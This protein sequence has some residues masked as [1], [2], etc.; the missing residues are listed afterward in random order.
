MSKKDSE[1]N[2]KQKTYE[3][4]VVTELPD[5]EVQIEGEIS[6]EV[7]ESYRKDAVKKINEKITLPGFRKG[8]VPEKI[9][10]S[11]VG[12]QTILEEMAEMAL[13]AAYPHLIID[14]KL[15]TIGRPEITITKIAAGNPLGFK[16][17]TAV[18][19][20]ITLPDYKKIA[21]EEMSKKEE[22]IA[23]DEKELE[24]AITEIRK[25]RVSH[26]GHDHSKSEEE[27]QKEIEKSMPELTDEFVKTLGSFENVAD[28]KE[29]LKENILQDKKQKAKEKKRLAIIDAV[30]RDAK[31]DVPAV[32]VESELSKLVAQFRDDVSR[33]GIDPDEYMKHIKKTED[34]LRKEWKEDARKRAKLQLA[35]G[36]IAIEEKIKPEEKEIEQEISHVLTH[37]KD[38]DPER[39]RAYVE[40]VL[41]NQKV[42]EFLESQS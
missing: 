28:F 24:N 40:S 18:I 2:T 26:E 13:G 27:H 20:K 23:V 37:Y 25:S 4:A 32:I 19:P 22:A 38:A 10:T 31:I 34:D 17:T 12:E 42:F 6:A 5:S 35:L 33:M 29:K 16:I 3:K 36:Q 11:K 14:N 1:E 9:L 41:I 8:N 21:K 15:N 7:L 39:A 30:I